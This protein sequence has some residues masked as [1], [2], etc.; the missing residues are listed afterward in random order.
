MSRVDDKPDT[1]SIEAVIDRAVKAER[2]RC[3]DIV[4]ARIMRHPPTDYQRLENIMCS[5]LLEAIEAAE[6]EG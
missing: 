3:A 2:K 1:T 4:R 5:Q 6:G